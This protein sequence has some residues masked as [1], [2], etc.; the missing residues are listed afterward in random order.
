MFQR[1]I[2]MA[3]QILNAAFGKAGVN[4]KVLPR[5][6]VR[7]LKVDNRGDKPGAVCKALGVKGDA[8]YAS[9]IVNI[10]DGRVAGSRSVTLS[11]P[12]NNSLNL[13][14][15]VNGS[16]GTIDLDV[17]ALSGKKP[18]GSVRVRLDMTDLTRFEF[19]GDP[20]LAKNCSDWIDHDN[21]QITQLKVGKEKAITD[22]DVVKNY[23]VEKG[24]EFSIR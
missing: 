11:T 24:M 15:E 3:A 14:W 13:R 4:P 20:E 19:N 12:R 17:G 8:P 23:L 2:K 22:P 6:L 1:H 10:K 7:K 16:M 18:A 21:A 9:I 5:D